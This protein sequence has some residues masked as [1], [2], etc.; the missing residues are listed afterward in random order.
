LQPLEYFVIDF[1]PHRSP[2]NPEGECRGCCLK[3]VQM[4]NIKDGYQVLTMKE[5]TCH[6]PFLVPDTNICKLCTWISKK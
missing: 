2:F 4:N 3:D 1:A 6:V 5:L